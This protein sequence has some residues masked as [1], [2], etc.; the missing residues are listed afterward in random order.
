LL[1]TIANAL[2]HDVYFKMINPTASTRRRI[3]LS[4][5]LLLF[6]AVAAAWV[7]SMRPDTIL[8]MVAWAFSIA[9][10]CFFPALVL[11]IFWRRASRAGAI[12]GMLVGLGVTLYYLLGVKFF[13]MQ[14]WFGISD[15]SAGVFGLA[16]GFVTIGLVSLISRAPDQATRE[17]I[18]AV[19]YPGQHSGKPGDRA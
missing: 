2:S 14:K 1:L 6:V 15:I 7:A 4:K 12:A 16:A 13:G 17:L 11:G 3:T 19:R 10:A 5:A 8:S 18:E 9:G